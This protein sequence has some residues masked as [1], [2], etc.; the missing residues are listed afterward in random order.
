VDL[1]YVL[2]LILIQSNGQSVYLCHND[3]AYVYCSRLTLFRGD[4]PASNG[5]G[6]C[7]FIMCAFH[8]VLCLSCFFLASIVA[9]HFRKMVNEFIWA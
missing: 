4:T 5:F 6:L 8:S 9:R 7:R 3:F 2:F 1:Q